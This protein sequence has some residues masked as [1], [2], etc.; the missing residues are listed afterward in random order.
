LG[1]FITLLLGWLEILGC[2]SFLHPML[3]GIWAEEDHRARRRNCTR[4]V[5]QR[6]LVPLSR[7]SSV[8]G[9]SF[10]HW[11]T[12]LSSETISI[13]V[14]KILHLCTRLQQGTGANIFPGKV[15]TTSASADVWMVNGLLWGNPTVVTKHHQQLASAQN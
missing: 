8:L 3:H 4:L 1:T 12:V 9:R 13:D 5:S 7:S 15:H 10:F 14:Q 6:R 11:T 2:G